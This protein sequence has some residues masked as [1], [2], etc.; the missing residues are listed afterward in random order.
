MY[1]YRQLKMLFLYLLLPFVLTG[2]WSSKEIEDL[3]MYTGMAIDI[4]Q[5]APVEKEFEMKGAEYS[6][7]NKVMTTI[8]IVPMKTVRTKDKSN[9]GTNKPYLNVSGSGDSILEIFR[10]F[11]VRLDQPIIGHHLKVIVISS[12][13]L[14]K[15]TI[16]QVTD[17][18]LRDNDIRPSTKVYISQGEAKETLESS[19]RNEVPSFH[20]AGMYR[21][22]MRT[23]K[24]LDSVT[25]SKLDALMKT[26]KS[27]VL[28]N[29]V[30]G[31]GEIE[32]S[33]AGII[34]GSSG[35][36]IGNL[37]QEDAEC[38]AWM[39]NNG[40]AGTIKAYDWDNQP[41]AYE[42]KSMKS[43]ITPFVN[44]GKISFKVN[45]AVE[46]RLI[47]TWNKNNIPSTNYYAEKTS[48]IVEEKLTQMIQR[49]MKKLQSTYKVD[50]AG[51]GQRLAIVY[52]SVWKQ[53]KEDW[54][55]TFSRSEVNFTYDIKLTD[56]GSFTEKE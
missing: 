21:N 10:Q 56:F 14:R 35:H 53:V 15:Q 32:F 7:H 20:I 2:C 5:P 28:Q 18:V 33:G 1:R 27:F 38:L 55:E 36:W 30:S 6:K 40:K 12:K 43:K 31:G 47:E 17:F 49:L 3:G 24:V 22:Q 37:N 44:E 26:K 29:L 9:T 51:F 42:I 48:Q 54:D 39:T 45:L 4:G 23:S 52:P 34:K 41:L 25:L 11:S 13:L 19:E 50:V 16:E 46:G 8:Q